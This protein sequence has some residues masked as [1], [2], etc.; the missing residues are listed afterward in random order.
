MP[1]KKLKLIPGRKAPNC[2]AFYVDKSGN[3]R[4][5]ALQDV[6]CLKE[7]APCPFF[8]TPK[9]AMAARRA[10]AIRLARIGRM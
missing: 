2:F 9:A 10:A 4:C 7:Y 8:K 5:D 3:P 6:Y 1:R